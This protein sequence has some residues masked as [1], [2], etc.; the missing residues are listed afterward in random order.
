FGIDVAHDL[1]PARI[2]RH[3]QIANGVFARSRQ[4]E[5]DARSF[6]GKKLV[7]NLHQD[8]G[9]VAHAR[10]GAG[11]AAVFQI[12]EYAQAVFDDQMRLTALDVGDESDAAGIL[13]ERG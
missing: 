4:L 6:L 10:I 2:L 11:G 8:S 1:P 12:A 9:A 13:V 7:R 3:E 5:A